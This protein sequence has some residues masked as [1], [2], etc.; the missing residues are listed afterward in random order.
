MTR[1]KGEVFEQRDCGMFNCRCC[2]LR[3]DMKEMRM[4]RG[5]IKTHDS[6]NIA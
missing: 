2:I 1:D 3:G 4:G 5:W 6:A